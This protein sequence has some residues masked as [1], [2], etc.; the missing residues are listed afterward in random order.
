VPRT[1]LLNDELAG[2]L[3]S[4]LAITV[5]TRDG[6]LWP[7][8]AWGWAVKVQRDRSHLVL[9]LHDAAATSMLANLEAHPEIA[10]A[11]DRPSTHRAW[12]VKGRYVSSRKARPEERPEI[13]RQLVLLRA[14][15]TA[16]GVPLALTANWRAWPCTGL[17]LL[18]THV[19]EQTPGPG[20]GEPLP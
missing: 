14:D 11:L 5:A 15:L 17:K 8:G 4:G 18:A 6:E 9:F 7:A 19:Y 3:E 16:I 13:E 2:H 20:T 12:Q 1:P 10:L